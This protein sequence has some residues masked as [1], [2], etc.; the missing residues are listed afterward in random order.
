[1]VDFEELLGFSLVSQ[2]TGENDGDDWVAS[3]AII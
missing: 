1:M 3:G 2:K